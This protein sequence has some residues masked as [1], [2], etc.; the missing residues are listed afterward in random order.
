MLPDVTDV[1]AGADRV[2]IFSARIDKTQAALFQRAEAQGVA[3]EQIVVQAPTLEDVFLK[4]T[5]RGLRE[6]RGAALSPSPL[7]KGRG[8]RTVAIWRAGRLVPPLV[9]EG[10][11]QAGRGS[12]I[13]TVLSPEGN[14]P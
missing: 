4:L 5:G 7:L 3:V 8:A 1:R 12:W 14:R 11:R 9:G 10:G 13:A 6:R 2:R